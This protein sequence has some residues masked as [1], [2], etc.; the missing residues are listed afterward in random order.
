VPHSTHMPA[1]SR[2][3]RCICTPLVLQE[4]QTAY[5]SNIKTRFDV[6]VSVNDFYAQKAFDVYRGFLQLF[7]IKRRE[8]RQL[9]P[10]LDIVVPTL[11]QDTV[12][13]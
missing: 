2:G 10:Q 8:P 7:T 4:L 11:L 13:Y 1:A 9:S 6:Q 12:N 5:N 3:L